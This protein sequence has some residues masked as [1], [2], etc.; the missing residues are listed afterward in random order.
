MQADINKALSCLDSFNTALKAEYGCEAK[1]IKLDQYE[2]VS[3]IYLLLKEGRLVYVGITDKP[4]RRL[5]QHR[6][7]GQMR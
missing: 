3:Y 1:E 5:K 4:S 6:K 2:P 7:A